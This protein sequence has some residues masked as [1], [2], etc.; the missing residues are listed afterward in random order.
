MIS[1][2]HWSERVQVPS[3]ARERRRRVPIV[4]TETY[5]AEASRQ[6]TASRFTGGQSKRCRS[7]R[8]S[9]G[10]TLLSWVNHHGIVLSDDA[11]EAV[12]QGFMALTEP[13]KT[14][15]MRFVGLLGMI[16]VA[17]GHRGEGAIECS[18]V[19]TW[20]GWILGQC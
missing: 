12:R 11:D 18:F 6:K 2:R 8:R 19:R 16:E 4:I 5:P 13:E 10:D 17:T 15:L 1:C 3:S 14:H 20:E 9:V 7:D